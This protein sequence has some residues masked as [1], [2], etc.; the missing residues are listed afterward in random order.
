MLHKE[1]CNISGIKRNKQLPA[2]LVL[3][4]NL[5]QHRVVSAVIT[6]LSRFI[7]L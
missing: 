4:N 5:Q 6:R 1:L 2:H 7:L 3:T